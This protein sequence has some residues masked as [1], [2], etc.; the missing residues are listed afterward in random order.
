VDLRRLRAGEWIAGLSGA[1]LI[2]ALFLPWYGQKG[3]STTVN[4]WEAFAVNDAILL[5]VALFAVAL[6]TATATQATAAVPM[7]LASTTA[8]LGIVGLILVVV[9]LV[10]PA[11]GDGATLEVGA[12]LGLAFALGIA[13]GGWR[14]MADERTPRK[15]APRVEVT[16]LRAP[17]PEGEGRT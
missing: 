16:R 2:V 13:A 1:G 14:A 8:L 11:G 10:W 15:A 6:I 12:W 9:R 17:G 7:A 4:A 5:L 3:T